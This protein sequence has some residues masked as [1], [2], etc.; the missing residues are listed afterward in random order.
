MGQYTDIL[1]IHIFTYN[2]SVVLSVIAARWDGWMEHLEV[3]GRE[4]QT[5]K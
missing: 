2:V 1:Y 5:R 3:K 4:F